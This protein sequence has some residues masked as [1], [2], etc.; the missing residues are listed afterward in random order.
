MARLAFHYFHG[1]SILH[2]WDGRC[3]FFGLILVTATL[4][5]PS[6][7][8]F[9]LDSILL[10]ILYPLSRLPFRLFLK[11]FRFWVI[12][13]LALFIFNILLTP[14]TRFPLFLWLPVSREG[15]LQGGLTSWRLGLMIV[16]A[17]LFTTVTR[18]RDLCEALVWILKPVPFLPERRI[19]LMVS[20]ALRFF[21]RITDQ[22]EEVKAAHLARLGDRNINPL[23]KVKFL[24]LPILRNSIL[25]VEEVTYALVARGYQETR[26]SRLSKIPF[27]HLLPVL[28][29]SGVLLASLWI[30]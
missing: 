18:P 8:W 20:L 25:R 19:G 11:D 12:F 9:S 17:V 22:A 6:I 5:Q 7:L 28:V 24:A 27:L 4:I 30:K 14:G 16:Y 13:L 10:F 1:D 29:M 2:R 21:S 3:K 23:R 15:L 26:P